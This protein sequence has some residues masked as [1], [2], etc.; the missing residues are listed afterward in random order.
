MKVID[1]GFAYELE[2]FDNKESKGQ[3]IQFVKNEVSKERIR[4]FIEGTTTEELMKVLVER[5]R[6]LNK[7]ANC[8][9][10]T[11]S[12]KH[13][14]IALMYQEKRSKTRFLNKQERK[15]QSE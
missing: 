9:E 11:E 3:K 6:F 14:D 7:K 12:I 2:N 1:E 4:V 8:E 13:L 10:N 15:K 5:L